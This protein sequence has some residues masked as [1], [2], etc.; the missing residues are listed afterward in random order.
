MG[1]RKKKEK[2]EGAMGA[3][4]RTREEVVKWNQ[5]TALRFQ[6]RGR[7]QTSP[8]SLR[9][10][11]WIDSQKSD[12]YWTDGQNT[13]LSCTTTRPMEIHQ[14]WTVPRQTQRMTTPSFAQKWRPQ[15]NHWSHLYYIAIPF[16]PSKELPCVSV[17]CRW[18]PVS[19]ATPPPPLVGTFF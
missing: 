13:A 8:A 7:H 9:G 14:Y 5:T 15:Y 2:T 18:R 6:T 12:R 1:H 17:K 19:L 3:R 10:S 4:R 16:L 11:L